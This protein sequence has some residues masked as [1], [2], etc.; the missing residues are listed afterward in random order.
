VIER[1]R[2][3]DL[4]PALLSSSLLHFLA[5]SIAKEIAAQDPPEQIGGSDVP[6]AGGGPAPDFEADMHELQAELG[7]DWILSWKRSSGSPAEPCAPS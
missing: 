2:P 6:E 7:D 4:D 1:G 5:R 3:G